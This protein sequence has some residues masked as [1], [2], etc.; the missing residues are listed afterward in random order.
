MSFGGVLVA[1][2]TVSQGQGGRCEY[3]LSSLSEPT[4]L[5]SAGMGS[6][7]RFLGFVLEAWE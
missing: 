2:E 7:A 3:R 5:T 6:V 4:A 1:A